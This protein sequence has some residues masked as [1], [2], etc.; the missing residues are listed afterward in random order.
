MGGFEHYSS[1][2]ILPRKGSGGELAAISRRRTAGLSQRNVDEWQPSSRCQ[3]LRGQ[4]SCPEPW[5]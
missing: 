2:E 1:H 4:S 3:R 5:I